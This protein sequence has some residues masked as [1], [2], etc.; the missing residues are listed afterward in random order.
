[1]R[2]TR[3]KAIKSIIGDCLTGANGRTKCERWVP[4]WMAFRRQP[5]RRVA[6]PTVAA[7]NRVQWLAEAEAE[8]RFDADTAQAADDDLPEEGGEAEAVDDTVFVDA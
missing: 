7:A 5:I 1:M 2:A 3:A 6:V 8:E 4:R